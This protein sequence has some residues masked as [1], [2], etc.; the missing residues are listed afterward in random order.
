MHVIFNM[1]GITLGDPGD[2]ILLSQ[3]SYVAF[4]ADFRLVAKYSPHARLLS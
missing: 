4:S 3:P 1:L 2:G